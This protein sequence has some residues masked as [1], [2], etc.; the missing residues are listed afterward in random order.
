MPKMPKGEILWPRLSKSRLGYV[1][2]PDQE[3][4][5]HVPP[6]SSA[7]GDGDAGPG[8]GGRPPRAPQE[9]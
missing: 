5:G 8:P 7:P 9:A 1:K 3:N 6:G 2:E 4:A